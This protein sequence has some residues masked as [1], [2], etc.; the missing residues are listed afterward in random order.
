M[1]RRLEIGAIDPLGTRWRPDLKQPRRAY[2]Q[3]VQSF[4]LMVKKIDLEASCDEFLREAAPSA[5]PSRNSGI[6]FSM[7]CSATTTA[8]TAFVSSASRRSM[9]SAWRRF[10]GVPCCEGCQENK[11]E[12]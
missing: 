7:P 4:R 6:T 10:P 3:S 11:L 2:F 1:R 9:R 12:H 8:N 5:N